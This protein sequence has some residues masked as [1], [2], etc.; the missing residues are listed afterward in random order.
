[1]PITLGDVLQWD[2][3]EDAR[4]LTTSY[5]PAVFVENVTIMEAPDIGKWVDGNNILLTSLYSIY[6]DK[7]K[8]AEFLDSLGSGKICALFVKTQRF[9]DTV[10]DSIV[11]A[12]H[13]YG[14]A[15]VEIPG[16]LRYIDIMYPVIAAIFESRVV[17]LSYHKQTL[18][19]LTGLA[20]GNK[21]VDS[22]AEALSDLVKNP[23]V[24]YD[25]DMKCLHATD[26]TFAASLYSEPQGDGVVEDLDYSLLQTQ[27]SGDGNLYRQ[28][29]IPV[30]IFG[31]TEMYLS[32]VERNRPISKLDFVAL[33][34]AVLVLSFALMKDFAEEEM[35]SR[36][37]QEIVEDIRQRRNLDTIQERL[38]SVNLRANAR[39]NVFLAEMP[40]NPI[41]R[42]PAIV[43]QR[44][45][46]RDAARVFDLFLA[47]SRKLS[48]RGFESHDNNTIT[49]FIEQPDASPADG[50]RALELLSETFLGRIRH[51]F[52]N[53]PLQIGYCSSFKSLTHID[54]M[55]KNAQD[56]LRVSRVMY[57]ENSY[58][59]YDKLGVYKILSM[60]HDRSELTACIP[61]SVRLLE[62]YQNETGLPLVETLAAYFDNNGNIQRTAKALFIHYKTLY[63]RLN[64]V[65][66]V[67]GVDV[68]NSTQAFELQMGLN[69]LR[70]LGGG[71]KA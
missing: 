64:K 43:K 5:N 55:Y 29:V 52:P 13:Q 40:A 2:I 41:S 63:Y 18:S 17:Q 11:D 9:V 23:V 36:F 35:E 38:A 49:A 56:A 32:I 44:L 61:P 54:E 28:M 60:A 19:A 57:G 33:E 67:A 58:C 20:L 25:A 34:N 62:Q 69:I 71:R 12:C 53:M 1:M 47:T 24:L 27:F 7:R 4:I 46:T 31:R 45:V 21:G 65:E 22:I 3:L 42:T 68:K 16:H 14:I 70:M 6:D 8:V 51:L 26:E 15:L 30:R 66:S 50:A 48:L 37:K 39:Y 59:D 10:P